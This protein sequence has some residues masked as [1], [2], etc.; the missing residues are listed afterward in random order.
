MMWP[1]E[2]EMVAKTLA[3]LRPKTYIEVGCGKSTSFYPLLV[4]GRA[5]AI[6]NYPEWCQKVAA[7]PV[8]RCLV[9]AGRLQFQCVQATRPDGSVIPLLNEGAARLR[10]H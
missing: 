9:Q 10:H 4:S 6:D 1:E 7:A 2:F 5:V 3:R 8:V